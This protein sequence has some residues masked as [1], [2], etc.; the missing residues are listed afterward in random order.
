MRDAFAVL[1]FTS[2]GMLLDPATVLDYPREL[3]AVIAIIVLVKPVTAY[4]I[5][6]VLRRPP[7]VAL[8]VGAGD[9]QIG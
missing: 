8:L 9:A 1:F 6:R 4:F 2:V 3:I 7:R 5:V